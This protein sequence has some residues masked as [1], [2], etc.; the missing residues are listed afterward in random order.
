MAVITFEGSTIELAEGETVLDGLLRQGRA[1]AYGCRSGVCQACMLEVAGETDVTAAQR[2]LT[3]AQKRLRYFL[4]CQCRPTAD[5]DVRRSAW[6][7]DLAQAI[8]VDKTWLSPDVMRLRLRADFAGYFAGQ[9]VTLW[10]NDH[11]ARSY[12]LAS[13]P[14]IDPYLEF[15]IR[16]QPQGQFSSWLATH[17]MSND[18]LFVQGP[19][20]TCVYRA[21]PEQP[22]LLVAMGTGLGPVYGIL[23]DALYQEH[24]G[25]V[26]LVVGARH[27]HQLYLQEELQQLQQTYP[28]LRLHVVIQQGVAN[29][30]QVADIYQYCAALCPDL[31]HFRVFI[32]GP[33][34]FVERLRQQALQAGAEPTEISVDSFL[35]FAPAD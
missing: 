24:E 27:G 25:P 23:R 9:Y 4:S 32:C 1:V 10:K 30:A 20:G 28:S 26:Y 14:Q 12:S 17:V 5:L 34:T 31:R 8:V 19:M 33:Q 7:G 29:G 2:G 3:A 16:H 15:H 21:R 13:H 22:L 11:L 6:G 18:V 35:P